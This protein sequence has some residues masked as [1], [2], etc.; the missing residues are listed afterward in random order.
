MTHFIKIIEMA[1]KSLTV[2]RFRSFLSVLG[3]IFG[4]MAVVAMM[5]V[6]EGAKQESL[7]Q[8]E[9]LGTNNLIVRSVAL[10]QAEKMSAQERQ[11]PGLT[12]ADAETLRRL[13]GVTRA[14]AMKLFLVEGS[15]SVTAG[16]PAVVGV[17]PDF[18]RITNVRAAQGSFVA[19]EHVRKQSRVCVLGAAAAHNQ[20]VGAGIGDV[21]KL[22]SEWFRVIGIL[23]D[24]DYSGGKGAAITPR[25]ANND[26]Y[27][28]ITVC[29]A[30]EPSDKASASDDEVDEIWVQADDASLVTPLGRVVKDT[31]ARAHRGVADYELLVPRELLQ[32]KQ[33]TIGTFNLVLGCI[34]GISLLVGGIGIM[35][36]MLA[37]VS[38]RT[39]EIGICRAI[40]ATR[41]DIIVQ[42]LAESVTL[43]VLG[44][45]VGILLGWAGAALI[46]AYAGWATALSLESVIAAAVI[47]ALV[48]I[49]FGLYPAQRAAT[50]DPI[51]ALRFE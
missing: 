16:K 35:N 28:P 47:S 3:I 2:H 11:S 48:G 44:G 41:S 24:K 39:R 9:L 27:I 50:M 18:A 43:T 51:A 4:V 49:G 40:G 7:R 1:A 12:L 13:P 37:T 5:A 6:G 31:L 33:R 19:E 15:A 34:A 10:T 36:I 20:A 23:E 38:E 30:G 14:A 29:A 42:F 21:Q 32:Q 46:A 17:E 45:L 8:I 22:G 25:N 26:V